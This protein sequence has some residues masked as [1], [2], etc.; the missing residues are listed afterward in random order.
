MIELFRVVLA[1]FAVLG[2]PGRQSFNDE[3][4]A[5]CHVN[6]SMKTSYLSLH[7]KS[8]LTTISKFSECLKEPDISGAL[9][10]KLSFYLLLI[11]LAQL[12][13]ASVSPS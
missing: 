12:P 6:I 1:E 13:F 8:I 9:K 11:I 10:Q 4:I 7:L 2:Q 5:L 3:K